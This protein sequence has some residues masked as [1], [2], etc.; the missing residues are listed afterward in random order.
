MNDE[1]C[2]VLKTGPWSCS[3]NSFRIPEKETIVNNLIESE[4]TRSVDIFPNTPP[5][6]QLLALWTWLNFQSPLILKKR[7]NDIREA[8]H[9]LKAN[10]LNLENLI[11]L[12]NNDKEYRGIMFRYASR[13]S[14]ADIDNLATRFVFP[15]LI[16]DF[17]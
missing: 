11:V 15:Q 9:V 16:V 17:F 2:L 12:S 8:I 10:L 4:Q 6:K 1:L 3:K 14:T 13:T 5:V 7:L